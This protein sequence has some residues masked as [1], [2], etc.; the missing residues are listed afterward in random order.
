M[1]DFKEKLF[2]LSAVFLAFL[3]LGFM[4]RILFVKPA[5]VLTG[6]PDLYVTTVNLSSCR[7]P[8]PNGMLFWVKSV[9]TAKA[10]A[11]KPPRRT[12]SRHLRM[13]PLL[14]SANIPPSR[15]LPP[16]PKA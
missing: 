12:R 1:R 4:I 8:L 14:I 15:S 11:M 10:M 7:S 3:V 13:L 2:P 6:P 5:E 16:M 9:P